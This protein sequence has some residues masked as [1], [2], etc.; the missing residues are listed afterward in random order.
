MGKISIYNLSDLTLSMHGITNDYELS[1]LDKQ[2]G[3]QLIKMGFLLY[4][5][6]NK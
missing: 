2:I 5:V 1:I 4:L 3:K 6:T